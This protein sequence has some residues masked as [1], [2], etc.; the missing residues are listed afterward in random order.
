MYANLCNA[1]RQD[2]KHFGAWASYKNTMTAR[3]SVKKAYVAVVAIFLFVAG[4]LFAARAVGIQPHQILG[5]PVSLRLRHAEESLRKVSDFAFLPYFFVPSRLPRYELSIAQKD[6][7]ALNEPLADWDPD[8]VVP[9]PGDRKISVKADFRAGP[10]EAR[11][12]VRYRGDSPVHWA[13]HKKSFL[14]EFPRDH[15]FQGMRR[16]N[17]VVPES[18]DFFMSRL[19]EH[20]AENVGLLTPRSSFAAVRINGADMGVYLAYEDMREEW[21]EKQGRAGFV[22]AFEGDFAEARESVF[23]DGNMAFW[24]TLTYPETYSAEPIK[25]LREILMNAPDA[26]LKKL[27]PL[28]VDMDSF[29]GWD[30]ITALSQA[31][32]QNDVP[33]SNNMRLLFDTA[34]GKFFVIPYNVRIREQDDPRIFYKDIPLLTKRILFIPE[35]KQ[36]RDNA[37]KK[38]IAEYREDDLAFY[39]GEADRMKKEFLRDFSKHESGFAYLAAIRET[40]EKIRENF[41]RAEKD[42]AREYESP[43]ASANGGGL[44][45]AGAAAL[46]LPD[47]FGLLSE[48]AGTPQGFVAR[49]PEFIFEPQGNVLRL[50]AG[51]YFFSRDMAIPPGI[52]V[53][54]DPG[55]R[56]FLGSDVSVVS[57]SP[58]AMEG[59]ADRPILITAANPNASWGGFAVIGTG[60]R[61]S[62]LRHAIISHGKGF[63]DI[64]GIA[65][66]GMLAFHHADA[67]ITDSRI[68]NVAG[69]DGLNIKYGTVSVRNNV[70]FRTASDALDCDSCSGVIEGNRFETIGTGANTHSGI[71]NIGGD[72]IDISFSDVLIKGN[73]IIGATD[74]GISVG[75]RSSP[76]IENNVIVRSSAGIAV[77]DSSSARILANVIMRN[78]IAVELYR[79]KNIFGPGTA[80]MAQ[81]ILWGNK[82]DIAVFPDGSRL[83]EG[84]GNIAE[85]Q[86]D[87]KPDFSKLLPPDLSALFL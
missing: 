18:Q 58:V 73:T 26:D 38:Y 82:K 80:F 37:L 34:R 87:A 3:Y 20:R 56:V 29:Y 53:V 66:T 19:N 30:V 84:D 11:V 51:D 7:R 28:V 85:S 79:K 62:V 60:S 23:S 81:S 54:F 16:L 50:S 17:L 10:Y 70:F 61:I 39:D 14:V 12:D 32:E 42:I 5:K 52:K 71:G 41:I 57:Y 45:A 72:A 63:G 49:H 4:G 22:L 2:E 67:A 75:E 64:N 8:S 59:D 46:R 43:S 21:L 55:V 44:T 83:E 33:P 24:Q 35:F 68:E 77:K 15:L 25:A 40:R 31:R 13:H 48:A 69:E 65:A 74:K 27:L 36:A 47:N 76:S 1:N 78:A 86:G 9:L 6:L